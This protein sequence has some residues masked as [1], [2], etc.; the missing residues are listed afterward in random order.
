MTTMT[1]AVIS[2]LA[3]NLPPLL[4]MLPLR[5]WEEEEGGGRWRE[6]K[7]NIVNFRKRI[8]NQ[9]CC[10]ARMQEVYITSQHFPN[11]YGCV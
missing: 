11:W 4:S 3:A 7:V 9:I 6:K 5:Y 8:A 2:L 10:L 1:R